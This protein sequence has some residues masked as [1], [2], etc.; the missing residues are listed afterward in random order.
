MRFQR[1]GKVWSTIR[2]RFL[3][4]NLSKVT[5][6]KVFEACV[7]KTMLFSVAVLPFLFVIRSTDLFGVTG[8]VNH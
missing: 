2:K 3:K 8:L 4:C 6:A 5:Q 7:E 1:A